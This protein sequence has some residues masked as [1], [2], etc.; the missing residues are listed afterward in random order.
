MGACS[1][2]AVI[3]CGVP[4]DQYLAVMGSTVL[5]SQDKLVCHLLNLC[6]VS[7]ELNIEV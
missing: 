3:R 7:V 5:I 2:H 1:L 6:Y 4:E